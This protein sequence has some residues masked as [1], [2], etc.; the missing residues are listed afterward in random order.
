[1]CPWCRGSLKILQQQQQHQKQQPRHELAGKN[2][3][4]NS[5]PKSINFR[6]MFLEIKSPI[7]SAYVCSLLVCLI[8]C[9]TKI[10]YLQQTLYEFYP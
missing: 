1:M 5:L 2:A 6:R 4:Y 9:P 7:L 10:S 8:T 3:I